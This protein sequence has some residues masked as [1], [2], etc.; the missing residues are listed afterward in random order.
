M[1]KLCARACVRLC[2]PQAGR[3]GGQQQVVV[4]GHRNNRCDVRVSCVYVFVC[5]CEPQAGREWGAAAGG[6]TRLGLARAV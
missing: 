6:R 3:G 4:E 2:E 5:I 1:R